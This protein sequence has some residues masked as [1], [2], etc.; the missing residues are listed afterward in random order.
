MIHTWIW[1]L[2]RFIYIVSF[3]IYSWH[4]ILI[5]W[6]KYPITQLEKLIL[7][8]IEIYLLVGLTVATI[9]IYYNI[10][11]HL[12]Q[13]NLHNISL[14]I[15]N[16]KSHVYNVIYQTRYLDVSMV[17]KYQSNFGLEHQIILMHI[18]SIFREQQIT[19]LC[20]PVKI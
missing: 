7:H 2:K 17:S 14:Y 3:L 5:F 16:R 11:L 15:C 13:Q 19:C 8:I 4:F 6:I 1:R 18:L 12:L 10:F 20:I 9:N